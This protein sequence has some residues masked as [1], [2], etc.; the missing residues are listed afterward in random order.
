MA[1]VK[2]QPGPGRLLVEPM[3]SD[4]HQSMTIAING[5]KSPRKGTIVR[6]PTINTKLRGQNYVASPDDL[7]LKTGDVVLYDTDCPYTVTVNSNDY[8]LI[9]NWDVIAKIG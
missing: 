8:H 7:S 6:T 1:T 3:I 4:Y 2:I 9:S 5:G